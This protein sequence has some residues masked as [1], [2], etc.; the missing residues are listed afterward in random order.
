MKSG[1]K[2]KKFTP[3]ENEVFSPSKLERKQTFQI[4]GD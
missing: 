1:I 3:K 2:K 4:G